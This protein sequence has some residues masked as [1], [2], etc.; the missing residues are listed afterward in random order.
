MHTGPALQHPTRKGKKTQEVYFKNIFKLYVDS[1][2]R[3]LFLEMLSTED[4]SN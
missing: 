1:I 4:E 2:S 3:V